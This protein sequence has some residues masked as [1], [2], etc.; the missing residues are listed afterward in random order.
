MPF[1]K[2]EI[3]M[4][5]CGTDTEEIIEAENENQAY[6]IAEGIAMEMIGIEVQGECTEEG[7]ALED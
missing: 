7:E 3:N 6:E 2:V 5:Y 4:G 1:Y